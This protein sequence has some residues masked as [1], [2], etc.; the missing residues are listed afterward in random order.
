MRLE[1][2]PSGKRNAKKLRREMTPPE[3]ALWLALR[4]NDAGLRFRKQHGVGDYVLDFYCAPARLA[5]EVDGEVHGRGD[6]PARDA[7]RDAA[8][9]AQG[10]LVVRYPASDV[11]RDL[12]HVER[13]IIA[14]AVERRDTFRG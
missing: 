13:Q 5:I 8:L 7:E 9:T 2:S 1:G 6:R 3:I 10:L 11:L 12:D 4:H 14:V